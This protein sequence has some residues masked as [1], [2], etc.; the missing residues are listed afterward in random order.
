MK[1]IIVTLALFCVG[2]VIAGSAE[3]NRV[4]VLLDD[5]STQQTHSLFFHSLSARGYQ[6]SFFAADDSRLALT[7]FGEYQYDHLIIFSSK[8]EEFGGSLGVESILQFVDD[9]HN[10][11]LVA[12]EG[13]SDPIRELA[14]ELGVEFDDEAGLVRDHVSHHAGDHTV[15]T[16]GSQQIVPSLRNNEVVLGKSLAG[17][18]HIAP[19]L[20]RGTAH[21]VNSQRVVSVLQ[22][23][24]HAYAPSTG[25]Q[26][27]IGVPSLVSVMQARN[28]A[29]VL[30]TGSLALFSDRYFNAKSD[31]EVASNQALVDALVSWVFKER[32][33]LKANQ[34][35]H[36]LVDEKEAR[37]IYRVK[38]E[39]TVELLVQEWNGAQWVAYQASDLQ[40]EFVR[41]DPYV[42]TAMKGS[43]T[44]V[45]SRTF[46]V[47]D[48]YGVF[49]LKVDYHRAGYTQLALRTTVPVRPFRHN[50][51]ER[52]IGS[53]YPYYASCFS[54]LVGLFLFSLAF[55]YSKDK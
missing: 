21:R 32:G 11:V 18:Q 16:L 7:K 22:A 8:V 4:L 54:M 25:T 1:T 6:L 50:E 23:T 51:Y 28:N 38:D 13:A 29:R 34:L 31:K 14:S 52:F 53:A 33:V 40:L 3:G 20:Y 2:L 55:L 35:A 36:H 12:D 26:P 39:L 47:P 30:L 45:F 46:T 15:L 41:V 10:L 44:G 24:S 48:V 17:K 5:S 9:G 42:R 49:A 37:A 19:V 43:S 27:L